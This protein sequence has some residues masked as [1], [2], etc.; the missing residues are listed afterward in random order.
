MVMRNAGRL[1]RNSETVCHYSTVGWMGLLNHSITRHRSD[2]K[3]L[4]FLFLFV[5]LVFAGIQ[6]KG[7]TYS[8]NSCSGCSSTLSSAQPGDIVELTADIGCDNLVS[9]VDFGAGQNVIFDGKGHTITQISSGYRG[10]VYISSSSAGGNTVKDVEIRGFSSGINILNSDG[11]TITN[12]RLVGNNTGISLDRSSD[13]IMTK[14]ELWIW[15][16][17]S[18]SCR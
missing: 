2:E 13:N 10:G 7:A 9:C 12:C 5:S 4:I 15:L 11:N 3:K 16:T 6:A 17:L 8:C 1:C 14:T 18:K